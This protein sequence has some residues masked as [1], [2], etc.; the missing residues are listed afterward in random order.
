MSQAAEQ[1]KIIF[2]RLGDLYVE[3]QSREA[4]A[5]AWTV[6]SPSVASFF[7]FSPESCSFPTPTTPFVGSSADFVPMGYFNSF[8]QTAGPYYAPSESVVYGLETVNEA[9]EDLLYGPDSFSESVESETTPATPVAAEL[10][11]TEEK[12]DCGADIGD[13]LNDS[14]FMV[15]RE[16]RMSLPCLRH[17]WPEA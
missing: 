12:N 4:W 9:A 11:F 15:V 3:I 7:C 8:H 17:T 13:E 10:P 1:E 16:R 2:S 5:Q 6:A 14:P